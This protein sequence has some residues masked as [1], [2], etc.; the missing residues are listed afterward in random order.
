MYQRS[1][2]LKELYREEIVLALRDVK[3]PGLK[4]FLTITALEIAADG[5]H[6]NVFY[7]ILGTAEEKK[8]ADAA[9]KRAAPYLRQV[10]RKKLTVKYIPEFHFLYDD[11][12]QKA[13]R[14]DKMLLQ[15]ENEK[16]GDK[17]K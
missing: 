5:K 10:L 8:K 11:T 6:A 7:S 2:R 4:G 17:P 3:D 13:S 15:L 1:D 16:R 9:L 14:I 12:P